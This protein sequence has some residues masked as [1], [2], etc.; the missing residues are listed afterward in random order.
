[1]KLSG[2]VLA[3]QRGFGI[4]QEAVFSYAEQVAEVAASGV[5]I[6]IVL[7][8]GNFWRARMAPYMDR[9]RADSMGMLATIMNGLAFADAL[10]AKGCEA[11]VM[12]AVH[13]P[14]FAQLFDAEAARKHLAAKR[15]V[16]F[17]GG[18]GNPYFTTDSGAALR[19][20]QIEAD[21]VIKGTLT[22]GVY[23]SDP[24]KNPE[25]KRFDSLTFTEA[26]ERGLKVMDSTAFSLCRDNDLPVYVFNI[27]VPGN[28]YKVV[29][30]GAQLGTLVKEELQ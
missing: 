22:D 2:E 21:I 16:I 27:T 1:M 3:G 7:G 6:G 26:L 30:D 15:I 4:E 24:H 29:V 28:L 25:A 20:L 8:G 9:C 13:A 23:D 17:A 19:G 5:E 11:V 10:R 18:T 14:Q 12:S